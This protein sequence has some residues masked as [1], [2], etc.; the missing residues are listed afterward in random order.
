[1]GTPELA[2][3]RAGE[4]AARGPRCSW[5]LKPGQSC[6]PELLAGGACPDSRQLLSQLHGTL[7]HPL[8]VRE[9]ENRL[10]VSEKPQYH[11]LNLNLHEG[12][13]AQS[14]VHEHQ[15]LSLFLHLQR[16]APSLQ[17]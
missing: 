13:G 10:V 1:M 17:V 2:V 16:Q 8:G 6:G 9:L 7:G 15:E 11:P 4:W 5:R 14:E 12:W 3:S